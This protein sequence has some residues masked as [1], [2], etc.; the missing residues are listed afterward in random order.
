MRILIAELSYSISVVPLFPGLRRFPQGRGF[1]QW[2]GNDSKALMKVFLPAIVG[3]VPQQMVRAI[4][5]FIEFC[6]IVRRSV[7]TTE[8]LVKLEELLT[9]FHEER[10]VFRTEGVCPD[11]FNLPCQ[12]A[13][14]HYCNSI[15]NFG[16]P[17]GL[18]SS[19]TVHSTSQLSENHGDD[20]IVSRLL[21]KCSSP[22]NSWINY[23]PAKLIL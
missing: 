1:K 22:T 4:A 10:E 12:H 19:I 2:T 11:G 21:A 16:A 14:K 9:K 7:I 23:T 5:T 8:D 18:C 3:H 20:Q 13:L 15:R 6:Y 17:N